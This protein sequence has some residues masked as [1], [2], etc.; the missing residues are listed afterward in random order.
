VVTKYLNSILKPEHLK[1]GLHLDE[2]SDD[3][4][5]L[6]NQYNKPIAYFTQKT[7][8]AEI[9]KEADKWLK[10]NDLS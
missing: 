10:E 1:H 9:H 6:E 3:F 4:V 7:T 8:A 5:V 2:I